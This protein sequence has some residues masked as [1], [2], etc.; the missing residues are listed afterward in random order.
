MKDPQQPD[1]E[2]LPSTDD[3]EPAVEQPPAAQPGTAEKRQPKVRKRVWQIGIAIIGLTIV[4]AA[5]RV[6]DP[7]DE[8]AIAAVP[9]PL[10]FDCSSHCR[11]TGRHG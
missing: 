1:T 5:R 10:G 2:P 6:N 4:S 9:A 11:R 8:A 7:V 3:F